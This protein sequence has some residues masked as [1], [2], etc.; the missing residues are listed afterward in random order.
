MINKSIFLRLL[1]SYVLTVLL[2]LCVVGFSMSYVTTD[3]IMDSK[4]E[5]MVRKAKKVNA[6]IQE[7]NQIDTNVLNLLTFL[8]QSF[9]SRIWVFNTEGQI[10]ATSAKDE[11]SIGKSVDQS[12]AKKVKNGETSE[13]NIKFDDV[14]EPMLSV[15]VP[16]GKDDQV[17]GGIILHSPVSGINY[18]VS[19][20]RETI[21]WVT[22][23]GIVMSSAVAFYMSWSIS[24]PLRQIDRAAAKIG[25][26]DY[27]ARIHTHFKDEI[28]ELA[29]TL[30]QMAE[31][32]EQADHEKRRLEQIRI[33]FLANSSHELRTPLTAMQGFLEALMDGLI[34]D[35][36]RPKYYEIIYKETIHMNRLVDDIMDL[37]RLENREIAL[38]CHPVEAASLIQKVQF[39]FEQE[40]EENGTRI[41]T[42][43][44][45]PLPQVHADPDR[46]EQILNN[47]VKNAV[48]FT[49]NGLITIAAGE[50]GD[51]VRLAVSDTGIGITKTDQEMIWER[52]FKV[53]RGRTK[54]Q[55]GTG[56][57]LAIVKQLVE[58]H[59][60]KIGVTSEVGSGTT[61]TVW[62]PKAAEQRQ[63]A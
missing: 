30:N 59:S 54:N 40:A 10:V 53:E 50:D 44:W 23:I 25:L 17:Y 48:K 6:A 62:I 20:I 2:G 33:D 56:L 37:T 29:T 3:Y 18:T 46:L 27:S 9:D 39:K 35:E 5:D 8:D 42:R 57:G 11:V 55:K 61:F 60:G 13:M 51:F 16:W 49:E 63:L 34:E 1:I 15:V 45:E 28:G 21:L 41:E 24:R 7:Y 38:S 31:K 58:L 12:V 14:L 32:L 52:L 26:G 36:G 22:L 47:L 43:I 19:N 4:K